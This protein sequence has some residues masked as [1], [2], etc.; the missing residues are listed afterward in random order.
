MS[1]TPVFLGMDFD[2]KWLTK[3]KMALNKTEPMLSVYVCT[4]K[5]VGG[6]GRKYKNLFLTISFFLGGGNNCYVPLWPNKRQHVIY[7]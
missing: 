3:V 6:W 1:A 7:I 2:I 5:C 4:G